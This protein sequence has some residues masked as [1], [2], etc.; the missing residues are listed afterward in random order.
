MLLET[1]CSCA[2]FHSISSL[3]PHFRC[4]ALTPCTVSCLTEF[5]V[6]LHV[7]PSK[8]TTLN[9]TATRNFY[10][11]VATSFVLTT[12]PF[13][14]VLPKLSTTQLSVFASPYDFL[15]Y[16]CQFIYSA[17]DNQIRLLT[18][19]HFLPSTSTQN[20][21]SSPP[22]I[23]QVL[24]RVNPFVISSN[25]QIILYRSPFDHSRPQTILSAKS[26]L[27]VSVHAHKEASF[28]QLQVSL[29]ATK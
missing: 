4:S 29:E 20:H 28:F 26:I 27:K 19:S 25:S 1:T 21:F 16:L 11:P 23:L 17:T 10:F 8:T 24:T 6:P 2:C 5:Q 12:F 9:F 22:P 18:V 7:P 3:I 13:H 15:A 14:P